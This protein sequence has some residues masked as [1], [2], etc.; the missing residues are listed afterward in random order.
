MCCR[1]GG[2]GGRSPRR[3]R[4]LLLRLTSR[5][6]AEPPAAPHRRHVLRQGGDRCTHAPLISASK[7][8]RLLAVLTCAVL[9]PVIPFVLIGELPGERWLRASGDDALVFGLTGAA[10]LALDVLLPIPSSV[11]GAL[12]GARLGFFAGFGWTLLGLLSGHLVGYWLG[13]LVPSRW[14]SELPRAPSLWAVFLSRPVPVLA[15]AV[16]VAAGAE[17]VTFGSFVATCAAGDGIYAAV[18]AADGAAWL[19]AGLGAAGLAVPM[20]LPVVAWSVWRLVV[21]RRLTRGAA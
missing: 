21:R 3:T 18:L 16:A 12:L 7:L 11:I 15:E 20:L 5:R 2:P 17:R 8:P 13:R 10:L 19:P 1:P 6:E 4:A 9:L 14:A